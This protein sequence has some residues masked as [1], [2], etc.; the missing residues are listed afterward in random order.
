MYN[1]AEEV[2]EDLKKC[3][4]QEIFLLWLLISKLFTY[5]LF[6]SIYNSRVRLNP[7]QLRSFEI[8]INTY[9]E[10]LLNKQMCVVK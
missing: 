4:L 2:E 6:K 7:I 1:V 9:Y 3:S 5:V 10:E 8:Y